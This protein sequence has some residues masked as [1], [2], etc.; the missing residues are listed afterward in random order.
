M[1][2][3]VFSI[4]RW[5][6]T[7]GT[8][9]SSRASIALAGAGRTW[10]AS[11]VGNGAVDALMRAADLALQ[12]VLEPGIELESYEVHASGHG[13]GASAFVKVQIQYLDG[14]RDGWYRGEGEH[15]NVLE[16]SLLAYIDAIGALVSDRGIDVAAAAPAPGH[17]SLPPRNDDDDTRRRHGEHMT[18]LYNR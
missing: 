11:A 9:R 10:R 2:E 3:P 1:S 15:A 7:S 6:A 8:E 13:H 17:T 5:S 14:S 12:S 4:V 18:S 16:A